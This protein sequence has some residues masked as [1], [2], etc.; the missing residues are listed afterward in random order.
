VPLPADDGV[1]GPALDGVAAED[2]PPAPADEPPVT[3]APAASSDFLCFFFLPAEAG[4]SDPL[5]GVACTGGSTLDEVSSLPLEEITA[6][7]TISS[8]RP[9]S[10]TARRRQ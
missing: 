3:P 1:P 2:E 6:I 5:E 8:T 4:I 7:R 9:P 10:A